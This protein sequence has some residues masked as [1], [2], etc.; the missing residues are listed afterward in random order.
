[1][2]QASRTGCQGEAGKLAW[3]LRSA[4]PQDSVVAVFCVQWAPEA[5]V[6]KRGL[7]R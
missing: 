6:P 2:E 4:M 1:M 7:G 3:A 5:D